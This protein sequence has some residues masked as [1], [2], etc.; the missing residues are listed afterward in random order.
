MIE[1][2][3]RIISC[4]VSGMTSYRLHPDKQEAV[5]SYAAEAV[6]I[7]KSLHIEHFLKITV[8]ND[9][10][11]LINGVLV[12]LG[13]PE[14]KKFY[15][16]LKSKGVDTI[17]ISKGLRVDELERF[18][19]DLASSG[20][21]FHSYEHIAVKKSEKPS[22]SEVP[23]SEK[24][25]KDDI[26]QV[27]RIYRDISTYSNIN[28]TTIDAVIG[29]IIANVRLI[30]QI[31]DSLIPLNGDAEDLYIHSFNVSLLSIAQGEYLGF[32]NALLYDI[33]FAALLHDIGKT[34]LPA[35]LLIRQY[36]LNEAEWRL[37]KKHP[38]YGAA[39]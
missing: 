34:L 10:S 26:L 5:S 37:M 39:L 12:S 28:M 1:E 31:L 25:L 14:L 6:D 11:M 21:F 35:D 3:S 38:E 36:A 7:I 22:V 13:Y 2:I 32:G 29:S 9:N 27:K 24:I 23:Y 20:N 4:F 16:K 15:I 19:G 30:G 17:I 8:N 18:F 33:G